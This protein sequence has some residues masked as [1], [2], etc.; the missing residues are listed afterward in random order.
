MVQNLKLSIMT[1][2][3][4]AFMVGTDFTGALLLVPPIENEYSVDITTSQWVLNIY[5]L[6]FSVVLAAGGR[7]GDMYGRRHLMMAGLSIFFVAS[8]CCLFAPTISLLIAARAL[9]GIGAACIWPNLLAQSTILVEE[10]K[11]GFVMGLILAGVTTGNVVGPLI[12]GVSVS[13]G[14]WR[15]FF[16]INVLL[17]VLS[18]L[19][20]QRFLPKEPPTLVNERVDYAGMAVLG[21]AI[22]AL[23]A[24]LDVGADWGWGTPPILGLFALSAILLIAFPFI[25][26]RVADPMV[27]PT[28]M[29]RREFL[30]ALSMNALII[31][32][33]FLAFLYFPQYMQK[34]MGWTV[35]ES[36]F[37]VLP[38]MVPLAIGSILSGRLYQPVGPKRLMLIGYVLVSFGSATLLF[39]TPSWGYWAL[40]PAM[41]LIGIGG[42]FAVSAAGAAAVGSVPP[43]RA[44]VAGALSFMVHLSFGA[45]G[46]AAGTAIMYVTSRRSLADGLAKADIAISPTDQAALNAASPTSDAVRQIL[47]SH[48]TET[49][50]TIQTVVVDAFANGLSHAYWLALATAL[51]GIVAAIAIDERKLKAQAS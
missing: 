32:A 4:V 38:L 6:T 17:A 21:I 30:L 50:H 51:L 44:G 29:R 46:V 8:L 47:A 48:S 36:S 28:L 34:T 43:A 19:F 33:V 10:E 45:M 42:A 37:G 16:L 49:V 39:L 35:L 18:L 15:L 1:L 5:A 3:V 11:R 12:S 24:A 20:A 22:M 41:L 2:G 26:R 14:D 31:P 25:E 13:M 27:P 9:Q 7:L 23:L 40:L